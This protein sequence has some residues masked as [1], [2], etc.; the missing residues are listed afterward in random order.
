M[1]LLDTSVWIHLLGSKPSF[2]I[3]DHGAR[4]VV[5]ALPIIQEVLQGIKDD[6]HFVTVREGMVSLP[7]LG[8]LMDKS[9]F[10]E[11]AEIYR[12]GRRK[13][14]TIRSSAD[15]LIAAI[16]IREKIPIMHFDRDFDY[17]ARYTP[18]RI[19]KKIS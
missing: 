6:R 7:I 1:V 4:L 16:A 2:K 12:E 15:C 9:L 13:G 10:I 11:A 19:A 17:I 8:N 18:L 5:T 14:Y 3:D